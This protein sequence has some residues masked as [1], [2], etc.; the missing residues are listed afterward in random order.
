MPQTA[1]IFGIHP[2]R[3]KLQSQ[4]ENAGTAVTLLDGFSIDQ[5]PESIPD[6]VVIL[7]SGTQSDTE[8][9]AFLPLLADVWRGK[10]ERR[11]LVHLLLQK[12]TTL[13]MLSVSDFPAAV[14][15][16]L[17]ICPFTMEG[18]WSERIMVRL[19]G[20]GGHPK[21][22]LDRLPIGKESRQF[23]HL[24]VIG[25]DSYSQSIA[26]TAA[27]V[28]HYPNYDG[29]ASRPLRTR[30]TIVAPGIL[31]LKD[32]FIARYQTLFD[33]SYYRT[34]DVPGRK[35]LLHHPIYEGKREDFVDVEWE[36][37]DAE[38]GNPVILD[39]LSL[40]AKDSLRQLTLVCSGSDDAANID[41]A[42]SLPEAVYEGDI[43]VWVRM[44]MD[45]ISSSLLQSPKYRNLIPFGMDGEGYDTKAPLLKMARMLHYFYQCSYGDEG[46]PSV[47]PLPE[48]EK[49][50]RSSGPMKMRQSCV[51]NVMT[52]ACKMHSLGHN[53][54]DLSTYYAL[55]REE[56]ETLS[57]TEHNRWS[58]ERLL[59]GTRPCTDEERE[60]VRADIRRKREFK[61]RDIH[62]D[63]C[64]YDEL[65]TDETGKDVRTYDYDLTA[66]IPLIV[67]SY[68]KEVRR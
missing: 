3:R 25:F 50:W 10:A 55:T 51:Y 7:T 26:L 59:S 30:I 36:F 14:N 22:G 66:C 68:L 29:R 56:I 27:R 42:I 67:E 18:A 46:I 49:A 12:D 31:N 44:H 64:A 32:P 45:M 33:H 57:R 61:A 52:M 19:P 43:P 2:I 6:E 54:E 15:E 34:V 8:A 48:V 63:L 21:A 17:D 23:A 53:P 39:K 5:L 16:V 62:Y 35:S 60:S 58:V 28:A 11:P 9:C 37:V 41:S 47:F 1:I 40:W 4:Y 65:G 38:P 13:R 24:V 20:L